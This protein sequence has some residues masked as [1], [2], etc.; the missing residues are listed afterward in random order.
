MWRRL[1][2]IV[3]VIGC[4]HRD[5]SA[6]APAVQQGSPA[7]IQNSSPAPI[8]ESVTLPTTF[9]GIRRDITAIAGKATHVAIGD[10]DGDGKAELVIADAAALRVYDRADREIASMPAE[11]GIQQLVVE[12][13]R[14]DHHAEIIAGWGLTRE[15]RDGKAKVTI[16]RLAGDKLVDEVVAAPT[17]TRQDIA[18][19]VGMPGNPAQLLIAY[20]ESK[21]DV[22]ATIATRG[23]TSWSLAPVATIR[24][25]TSWAR[26]DVDGDGKPD[27]V[28]GRLYGDTKEA[29]GDAFILR[30]ATRIPIPTTRGVHGLAIANLGD[31]KTELLLGDGW[32]QNY[33]AYAKGLV[34]SAR[35]SEGAFHATPIEDTAGQYAIMKILVADLDGDG[36]PEIVTQGNA[37]V[38]VYKRVGEAWKGVTVA[39]VVRDIAVGNLDGLPGDELVTLGDRSEVISLHDV[40][41]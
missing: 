36:H 37:Y 18:A 16:H 23:A 1:L 35:W 19:I 26:G 25:A 9:P 33:G 27:L 15:H 7:G 13:L 22:A 5:D 31:G 38:R 10:L 6:P 4:S 17:T 20:F 2:P 24:M 39:G 11:A 3:V 30:D 8:A 34:T 21:Y 12:D 14:G 29:A 32:H 28:V 41:W 40:N